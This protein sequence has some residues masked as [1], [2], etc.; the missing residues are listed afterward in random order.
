MEFEGK[1][2]KVENVRKIGKFSSLTVY[3]ENS[4]I[5]EITAG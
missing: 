1:T 3:R 4:V 2:E 5:K